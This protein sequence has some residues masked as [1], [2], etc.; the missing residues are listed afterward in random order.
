MDLVEN[1]VQIAPDEM[2]PGARGVLRVVDE[3]RQRRRSDRHGDDGSGG[4]RERL[5]R[6]AVLVLI[7]RPNTQ[8][9]PAEAE[10]R[11][12]RE[13]RPISGRETDADAARLEDDVSEYACAGTD[14]L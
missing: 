14:L 1:E 8:G 2:D 12:H 9:D 10:S 7:H 13:G 5:L 6:Y 11:I 4:R 3:R